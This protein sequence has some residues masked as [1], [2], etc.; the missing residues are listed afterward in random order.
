MSDWRYD[1]QDNEREVCVV[2][3]VVASYS[4]TVEVLARPDEDDDTVC[5]RA[6]GQLR[7]R[8]GSLPWGAHRFRV[9]SRGG[10]S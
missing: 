7:R 8:S 9:L 2:R 6:R 4:G 5:A 10:R 3:Y 1:M